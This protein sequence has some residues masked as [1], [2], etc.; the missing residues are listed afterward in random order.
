[1]TSALPACNSLL[2]V[3]Y[4]TFHIQSLLRETCVIL[5]HWSNPGSSAHYHFCLLPG[6]GYFD[7]GQNA[8]ASTLS[9]KS[10]H[11]KHIWANL[12]ALTHNYGLTCYTFPRINTAFLTT[13]DLNKWGLETEYHL[14]SDFQVLNNYGN[15]KTPQFWDVAQVCLLISHFKQ[16]ILSV[17]CI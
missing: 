17:C 16:A 2:L 3:I 14:K 10:S 6:V 8:L 15:P 13:S 1:M 7:P 5:I 4:Q 9:C 12:P 11:T